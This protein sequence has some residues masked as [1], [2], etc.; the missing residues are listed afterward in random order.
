M[1]QPWI[2][3]RV[4]LA[5][6]TVL[7]GCGGA[8]LGAAG[9]VA[10]LGAR[11]A[12]PV[13]S[14]PLVGLHPGEQMSYEVTMAGVIVGE[15]ALAVGQPGLVH[16]RRSIEVSSSISSAGAF[17]MIK[18]IEDDLTSTID[19]DSGLTTAIVAD[20]HYGTQ[21]YHADGRFDH[22]KVDLDWNRGDGTPRHT[23]M[24]FG[25]LDANDAH[26][27]MAAMRMW[28]GTPGESHRMYVVG[29]RK[30]WETEATWIG[31]DV[32]GTRLGNQH[33]IRIDGT[34]EQVSGTLRP[35]GDK[36]RRTFS[37]WMSDDADR[38]PLRI[39]A[40]TELGDVEIVLTGYERP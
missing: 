37:I 40:H 3:A 32:I 24:D 5:L 26:S 23:H 18:E 20:V 33:A 8:G 12:P 1:H 4:V 29:G 17:R 15:A 2:M 11:H 25:A 36:K 30:I 14:R 16:G 7:A 21:K 38:V 39:V 9:D 31:K 28:E 22:D 27:A 35:L 10:V 34:S 6:A 19:L 13:A